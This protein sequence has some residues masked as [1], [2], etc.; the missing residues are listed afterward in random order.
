VNDEWAYAQLRSFVTAHRIAEQPIS[1]E[2]VEW[3]TRG[4]LGP[5]ARAAIGSLRQ[6]DW[7]EIAEK[8]R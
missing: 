5:K 7:L 8:I 6:V 1:A 3:F 2:S 4:L